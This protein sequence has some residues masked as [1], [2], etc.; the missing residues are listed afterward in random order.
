ML[1]NL[2]RRPNLAFPDGFAIMRQ[3]GLFGVT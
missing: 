1:R 3:I 2:Q